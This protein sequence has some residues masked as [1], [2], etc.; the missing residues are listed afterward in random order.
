MTFDIERYR[1]GYSI[2]AGAVVLCGD[3]ILLARLAYGSSRGQWS[4]PGG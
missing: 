2:G 4:L 1:R 3:Q